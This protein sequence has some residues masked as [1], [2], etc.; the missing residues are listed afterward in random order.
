MLGFHISRIIEMMGPCQF[1]SAEWRFPGRNDG[2]PTYN[3]RMSSESRGFAAAVQPVAQTIISTPASGL[4]AGDVKI[5]AGDREIPAYR[6]RPAGKSNLP[7]VLVV[8]EIWALHEHFKDVCRRLAK[9]GYMAVACDFFARQGDPAN[10]EIE[11]IRK[12]VA[13]VPDAQVMSDLDAAA[14]WA[15]TNGGD[16]SRMAIT[17]FCWGGRIVWLYACAQLQGASRGRVV[18]QGRSAGHAAAAEARDRRRGRSQGSGAG[19]LRRRGCGHS[20]RGRGSHARGDSRGGQARPKS[21]R[22]PTLRMRSTPTTVRVIAGAKPTTAGSACSS[23]SAVTASHEIE[24]PVGEIA[25]D[26]ARELRKLLESRAL[27]TVFQ[28]IYGFREAGVIGFEALVRGPEGTA[29][30]TPAALFAAAADEGLASELNVLCITEVLRA[31]AARRYPGNLFLNVSPQF[32]QKRGFH[33]A[34]AERFLGDLGIAPD[35]VVIE[36]TETIRHSIFPRCTTRSCSIAR[37]ASGS[38]SMTWARASQAFA[39]G[40]SC[41]PSS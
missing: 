10:L 28:P 21:T 20:Q 34:R 13:Q 27:T 24:I 39:C 8:H 17:G 11:D 40:R 5:R 23:G 33:R 15:A 31:F 38:P 32:I 35:R 7:I 9:A 6:A 37:W 1:L 14:Q 29:L 25:N 16:A 2:G 26:V 3:W 36:L 41:A 12:I 22:T 30:Q 4:D 18:W 19:T